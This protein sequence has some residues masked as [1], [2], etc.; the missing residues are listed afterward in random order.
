MGF[1]APALPLIGT[2]AGGLLGG[3]RGPSSQASTVEQDV[4]ARLLPQFGLGQGAAA[5]QFGQHGFGQQENFNQPLGR[6]LIGRTIAGQFLDPFQNP[7]LQGILDR[8]G[9]FIQNRLNTDFAG[10]GR[11]LGAARPAA[12]D[13]LGTFTSQTLFNNFNAERARQQGALGLVPSFDPTNQFFDRLN[14]LQAAAQGNSVVTQPLSQDRLA[15]ALGGASA[16]NQI[17]NILGGMFPSNQPQGRG[18]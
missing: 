17:G 13:A 14:A 6:N 15:G 5:S 8:G 7:G 3:R 1:L 4:P 16:G 10:S 9:D 11:N 12:A 2:V 18:K